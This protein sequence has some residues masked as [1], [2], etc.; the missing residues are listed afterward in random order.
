MKKV[1]AV[2]LEDLSFKPFR[3]NFYIEVPELAAMKRDQVE[4]YRNQ[5]EG[6]KV[7]GKNCPK[8]IKSWAQAGVSRK[9]LDLLKK[10]GYAT[11]TPIQAQAITAIMPGRDL[12]GIAK[13]GSG[14]TLAFLIP[15][16]RHI[17]EQEPLAPGD[18]ADRRDPDSDA[19][20][21]CPD[22]V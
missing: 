1:T 21:C 3:K 5:L 16:L 4:E 14:K 2:T 15:M 11:P 10:H 17:L 20:T 6:I 7:K 22:L 18:G 12:I 9:M 19:R 13:T 8:P